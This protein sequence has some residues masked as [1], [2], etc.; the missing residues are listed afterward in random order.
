MPTSWKAKVK[1][2]VPASVYN[3]AMLTLPFLYRTD[4]LS[5]ETNLQDGRGID[6]LLSQL[7]I[8]AKLPGDIVECGSSRCGASIIM[9]NYLRAQGVKKTIYACDS[10]E[11]FDLAELESENESNLTKARS[12]AFTSTS[13]EYVVK[14]ISRLGFED[15]V[16]PVKGFFKDTLPGLTKDKLFSMALIDC[17]L[18]D[19]MLYC[20]NEVWSRLTPGGRIVFDD[21]TSEDFKG[22]K[23][24]IDEFVAANADDIAQHGLLNRLYYVQKPSEA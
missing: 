9:A 24:A 23:Q 3:Q 21:Y 12:N 22:S 10:Y 13:Y 2:L 17:D 11:G 14:K 4:L 6:D 20:T 1:R 18:Y 7:A 16:V 5:Y 19:S 15:Y 8:V